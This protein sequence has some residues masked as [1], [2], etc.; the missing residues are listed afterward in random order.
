[1]TS[2][3]RISRKLAAIAIAPV[4]NVLLQPCTD[5]LLN[6]VTDWFQRGIL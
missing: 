1:M 2:F 5:G 6:L 4:M 3:K